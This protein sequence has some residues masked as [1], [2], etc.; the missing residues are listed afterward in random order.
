[1]LIDAIGNEIH[2]E[3][4]PKMNK[5][6]KQHCFDFII[7][8]KLFNFVKQ[9]GGSSDISSLNKNNKS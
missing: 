2:L 7:R 3:I 4:N 6:A 5:Q 9:Y 1:M 8:N